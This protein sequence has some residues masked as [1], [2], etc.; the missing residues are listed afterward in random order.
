[1]SLFKKLGKNSKEKTPTPQDAIQKIRDVEDLLNKKSAMAPEIKK[2]R[3]F[4]IITNRHNKVYVLVALQ[5]L[6]RKKRYEQQ[7]E[8]LDGTLTTLEYQRE[9]LENASSNAQVLKVMGDA[10]KAFKNTH[11][12]MNVDKIHDLMDDIAEQ[13]QIDD[14]ISSAISNPVGFSDDVDEDELLK[15]LE[16]LQDQ[17]LEAE[18]LNIPAAPSHSLPQTSNKKFN[19][20]VSNEED[21][22]RRMAAWAN[23]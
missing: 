9:V 19:T 15:E 21:E 23:S 18:L 20:K 16:D 7:L 8:K 13:K 6:R 14:E 1:M 5:A 17:D 3:I 12:D 10:S 2:A 22:L 11:K 4:Y